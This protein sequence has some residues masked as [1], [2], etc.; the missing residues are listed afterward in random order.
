M[1]TQSHPASSIDRTRHAATASIASVDSFASAT[2]VEIRE[3]SL[4]IFAFVVRKTNLACTS[5]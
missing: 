3:P 2:S 5:L 4:S 1:S